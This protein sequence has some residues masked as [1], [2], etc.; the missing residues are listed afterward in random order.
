MAAMDLRHINSG[1]E[2]KIAN[3]EMLG[4]G[5]LPRK[6]RMPRRL[7]MARRLLDLC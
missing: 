1:G 4:L 7:L 2:G 5:P 6:E 3:G